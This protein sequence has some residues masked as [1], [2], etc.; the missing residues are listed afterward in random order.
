[1]VAQLGVRIRVSGAL[2]LLPQSVQDAAYKAMK[3]TKHYNKA[4]LNICCPYTSRNEL[5]Q[6]LSDMLQA[7]SLGLLETDDMNQELIDQSL[8]IGDLPALQVLVRTSG[9]IRLSDYMLWQASEDCLL[10]F[11]GVLWPEFGFM[12]MLKLILSYQMHCL[13]QA[14]F[15]PYTMPLEKTKRHIARTVESQK[16]IDA[17]MAWLLHKRMYPEKSF[18][19]RLE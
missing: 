18:A 10:H 13:T 1:V 11:T 12:D 7:H 19:P 17:Y 5:S 2:H 14:L 9:E 3:S 8:F 6:T 15:I 4:T 16:R